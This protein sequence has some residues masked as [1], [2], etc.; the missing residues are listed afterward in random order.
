LYINKT[1]GTGNAATIIGTLN[2]TT[3]VKSGG[4]SSQ[5]LKADGSVD[6]STY[7]TTSA[8]SSTYLALAGGTLTGALSGTSATFSGDL[9]ID[10]NTLYVDSTNNRVGIGTLGSS[11]YLLDVF[12]TATF[13]AST[14]IGNKVHIGSGAVPAGAAGIGMWATGGNLLSIVGLGDTTIDSRGS[15]LLINPNGGNVGIGTN[16]PIGKLNLKGGRFI[17]TASATDSN[18]YVEHNGTEGRVG[19]TY[20]TGGSYAPLVFLTSDTPRMY[21][22]TGGDVLVGMTSNGGAS[23]KSVR[24]G[25]LS[26]QTTSSSDE[27]LAGWNQ[28]TSGDNKFV[29]FYTEANGTLRGTIDYNRAAGLVRYNATSD[30]NLKNIIGDSDVKKSIDILN[31]TRIREYSWKEDDSNKSQI[32]VIAQELY[33]T[34]KGAVSV[35]SDE[36]LLGTEDYKPWGV[37]KTAFTFHLIAGWQKHEQMIQE[38]Q[39]LITSLQEQINNIVATK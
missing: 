39:A 7:L 18:T 9:T 25:L 19:V 22:T 28:A 1:S 2:A 3:L 14:T 16:T 12:G 6:S 21:I 38:Q 15:F 13:G 23:V 10:T 4:T 37:D 24:A 8:A 36:E 33:E 35:G 11:G 26:G 5:F 27:C 30:K 20:D 31:S 34:Y 32:G 29:A 17:V